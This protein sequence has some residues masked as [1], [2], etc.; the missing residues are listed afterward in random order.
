[1]ITAPEYSQSGAYGAGAIDRKKDGKSFVQ[2]LSE[3][4]DEDKG[5]HVD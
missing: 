3:A 2:G 1:V 4:S 5:V